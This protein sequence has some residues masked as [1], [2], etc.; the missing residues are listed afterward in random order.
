[1]KLEKNQIAKSV[2]NPSA[3]V[4]SLLLFSA[5]W[6]ITCHKQILEKEFNN[7]NNNKMTT[8]Y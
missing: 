2:K 1:M 7:K 3:Q 6:I 8:I 5:A 4:K